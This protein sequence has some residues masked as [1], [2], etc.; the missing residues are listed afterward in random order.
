MGEDLHQ[1]LTS[2]IASKCWGDQRTLDACRLI[3]RRLHPQT[4]AFVCQ[5]LN[6]LVIVEELFKARLLG[7]VEPHA[8]TNTLDVPELADLQRR[9]LASNDWLSN[10]LQSRA[11]D[12]LDEK[13]TFQFVDGQHGC[14]SIAEILLHLVNH[15]SYHR[16]AI[17]HALDKIGA[18]RPPD[19]LSLFLHQAQPQRRQCQDAKLS[20][21]GP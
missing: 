10:Y 21:D 9:K 5:Q 4:Y 17:G 6:H 3:D 14:M 13:V 7:E 15:G 2:A 12:A 19:T 16:G 1:I 18:K 11:V 8:N 20:A